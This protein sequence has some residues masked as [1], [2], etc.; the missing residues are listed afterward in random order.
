MTGD[1]SLDDRSQTLN[2]DITAIFNE[3]EAESSDVDTRFTARVQEIRA[4]WQTWFANHAEVQFSLDAR[5]DDRRSRPRHGDHR[6]GPGASRPDAQ[7]LSGPWRPTPK[8]SQRLSL[9]VAAK[10]A[11]LSRAS[12]GHHRW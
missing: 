5:S 9:V 10:K 7:R 12:S 1:Q 6:P 8:R 4:T 11:T 3:L 2:G